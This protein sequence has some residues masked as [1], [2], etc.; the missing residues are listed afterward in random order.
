[1]KD[2][3]ESSCC[4]VEIS[5]GDREAARAE[6]AALERARAF[7]KEDGR[8]YGF[9]GD[10]VEALTK[11]QRRTLREIYAGDPKWTGACRTRPARDLRVGK[12]II[13]LF[14]EAAPKTC[15]NFRKLCCGA[16]PSKIQK[17][18]TLHYLECPVHR[19][20]KDVLLQS[21]D[22]LKGNGS[23]GE[24]VFGGK[25]FKDER[26]GLKLCHDRAGLVGM[27]NKGKNSNTSQ[28]YVTLKPLPGL[29]GKHVIFGEIKD[30]ESLDVLKRVSDGAGSADGTPGVP[31]WISAC[32]LGCGD[33]EAGH[34]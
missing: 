31:V 15:E 24:S 16:G 9:V 19:L 29:D 27:A 21:G 7:L 6:R 5:M 22:V 10:R 2:S 34:Q 4:Y 26:G 1:M 3:D 18:K 14:E 11:A 23:S 20:E 13:S 33:A 32:G 17:S 28:F 12:L 8:K 30:K 25:A